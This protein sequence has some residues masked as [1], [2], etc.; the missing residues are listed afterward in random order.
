MAWAQHIFSMLFDLL[1]Y[2]HATVWKEITP[3][4]LTTSIFSPLPIF[5]IIIPLW[6]PS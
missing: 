1:L 6:F 3:F 2:N 4:S 5:A